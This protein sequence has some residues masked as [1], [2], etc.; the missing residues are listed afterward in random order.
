MVSVGK[1]IYV[2]D[3]FIF[4][5]RLKY[6]CATTSEDKVKARIPLLLHGSASLWYTGGLDELS[7]QGLGYFLSTNGT[8]ISP[9]SFVLQ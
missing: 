3:V 9:S 1:E 2:R 6:V 5:D 8:R 4:I 7:K